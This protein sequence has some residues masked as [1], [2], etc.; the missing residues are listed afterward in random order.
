MKKFILPI[1]AALLLSSCASKSSFNSF[2]SENRSQADFS[3]K[4]PGFFVNA[5]IPKEDVGEYKQL[6]K[7]VR[8]YKIMT[9][10]NENEHLERQFSKLIRRGNYTSVFKVN[11]NGDKVDFYFLTDKDKIEE[12]I[13]RVKSEDEYVVLGL[14]TSILEK[15]LYAFLENNEFPSK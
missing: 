9:F 10:S 8:K 2:Y 5:F 3:L 11:D 4:V 6:F 1:V 14:K 15:E 7:K 13:L 12:V